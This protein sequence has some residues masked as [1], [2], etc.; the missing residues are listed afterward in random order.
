MY[1]IDYSS[2][3]C[4]VTVSKKTQPNKKLTP[5]IGVPWVETYSGIQGSHKSNKGATMHCRGLPFINWLCLFL[6][7]ILIG[8]CGGLLLLSDALWMEGTVQLCLKMLGPASD[9]FLSSHPLMLPGSCYY[10]IFSLPL[11]FVS[12]DIYFLLMQVRIH[13]KILGFRYLR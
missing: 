8:Q 6:F 3:L 5:E 1:N 10:L 12:W 9:S 11:F 4:C 13:T 7:H 2:Y